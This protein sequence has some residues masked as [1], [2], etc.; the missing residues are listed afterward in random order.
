MAVRAIM[1]V[2]VIILSAPLQQKFGTVR[3]YQFGM[4]TWPLSVIFLPI[5]NLMSRS[6]EYGE[7]SLWFWLVFSALYMCWGIGSLVWRESIW[8]SVR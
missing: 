2:G 7:N 4:A 6:K 8:L 3:M 1:I 5:L